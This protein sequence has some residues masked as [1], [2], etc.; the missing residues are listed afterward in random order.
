M[1]LKP[2]VATIQKI[3]FPQDTSLESKVLTI[4]LSEI[5]IC[6]SK[7]ILKKNCVKPDGFASGSQSIN[8]VRSDTD[9]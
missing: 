2:L 3:G 4:L 1:I 6:I 5:R 9:S 7:S 8:V